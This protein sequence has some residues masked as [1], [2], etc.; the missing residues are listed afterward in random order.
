[1]SYRT[2]ACY[3]YRGIDRVTGVKKQKE[4]A[5]GTKTSCMEA[6][7]FAVI[8]NRNCAGAKVVNSAGKLLIRYW[9]AE[10]YGLNYIEY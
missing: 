5:S 10:G 2:I 7:Q 8:D 9:Y 1:M 6:A 4:I 3:K